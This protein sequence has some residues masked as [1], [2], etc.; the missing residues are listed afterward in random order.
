MTNLVVES[1]SGGIFMLKRDIWPQL[2]SWKERKHHPLILK[3]LRQTGKTY[4]VKKFGEEMYPNTVYLD[5]RGNKRIHSAFEG[6]FNVDIMVMAISA[7]VPEAHFIPNKTLIILDE[8]QD[9]PNARSSLKYWDIDGRYDVIATGSFLGVK[10]FREPYSR[11]VPVGYEE[12]MELHPLSFHEFL[13]NSGLKDDVLD[14]VRSSLENHQAIEKTVHETIRSLYFQ[15]LI[16]GGMPEADNV[17]FDTH[18]LNAVRMVQKRILAS[19]CD[20]FGRSKDRSG[21]DKVNEV[22]KLRA[23]ACLNSLPAQLSKEYKKFQYSLVEAKGHSPEKA[24]GLQY[25]EDTG[26]VVRSYNTRSISFPLE[27]VKI[28]DEFKVFCVDTGLLVSQLGTDVPF[29]ILSGDISAYKGAIAE[30]MVAS[31]FAV[32][33]RPLFY[34]HAPSGSPELDFLFEESGSVVIIECK[35]TNN[36]ATS[37]KHVIAHPE[38]YGKHKAVK[39][40]DTN[41]GGGEGFDTYPLYALGFLGKETVSHIIPT[42]DYGN[43]SVPE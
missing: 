39:F 26:L 9:C 38:K 8:I 34:Y 33:E 12:Q 4:I 24:D 14:Y 25:L 30:N 20:D 3:G 21:N 6:D 32:Q 5:L 28:H 22:L 27:G 19:I 11:G 41:V 16:V 42:V 17:F 31:A 15:Y 10:G 7:A 29:M 18:D 2:V 23:E 43:L 1:H 37:M 40:A 13:I 36:R 35:S